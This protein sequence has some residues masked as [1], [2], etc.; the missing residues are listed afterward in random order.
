MGLDHQ[1]CTNCHGNYDSWNNT[2]TITFSDIF[3]LRSNGTAR[4][5]IV[6]INGPV[7]S[8]WNLNI[9]YCNLFVNNTNIP[10]NIS[11]IQNLNLNISGTNLTTGS[12]P[13]Q[14]TTQP[15]T[16]AINITTVPGTINL[17]TS[18]GTSITGL[19]GVL[20]TGSAQVQ[21]NS[22]SMGQ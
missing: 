8:S 1:Q 3:L 19:S 5:S 7:G 9:L 2:I 17:T 13:T 20:A 21:V 11:N 14:T 16:P 4:S 10:I 12:P 15:T 18:G 22:G 6:N